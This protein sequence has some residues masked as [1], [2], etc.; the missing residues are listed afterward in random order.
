MLALQHILIIDSSISMKC[1]EDRFIE[2]IKKYIQELK[3]STIKKGY[4]GIY[5]CGKLWKRH[6]VRNPYKTTPK[7]LRNL[8]LAIKFESKYAPTYDDFAQ[9]IEEIKKYFQNSYYK[10]DNQCITIITNKVIETLKAPEKIP[11]K[12]VHID[13]WTGEIK[14][15]YNNIRSFWDWVKSFIN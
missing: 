12:I 6:I 9:S 2:Y 14:I 1:N 4:V 3:A 15:E 11:Y 13:E 7:K 5:T 10:F 8:K